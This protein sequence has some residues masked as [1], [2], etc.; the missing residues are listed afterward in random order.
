MKF[1]MHVLIITAV[2][3]A[4]LLSTGCATMRNACMKQGVRAAEDGGPIIGRL[5]EYL[6]DGEYDEEP[7][8]EPAPPVA[9]NR[10]EVAKALGVFPR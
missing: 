4:M 8:E 9:L 1:T 6:T 2:L 5:C 10:I 3:C 7:E